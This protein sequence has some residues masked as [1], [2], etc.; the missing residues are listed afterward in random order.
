MVKGA[1]FLIKINSP[2]LK[3]YLSNS[4]INEREC[5]KEC[6]KQKYNVKATKGAKK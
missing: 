1:A 4:V 5:L 2:F 6:K 3:L